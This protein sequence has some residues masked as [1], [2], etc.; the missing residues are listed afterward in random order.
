MK[1]EDLVI[2]EKYAI[3]WTDDPKARIVRYQGGR[4]GFLI[5]Q[6]DNGVT[7]HCRYGSTI[8]RQCL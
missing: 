1:L 8:I 4:N 7:Y 6:E 2:G 3:C 5:F